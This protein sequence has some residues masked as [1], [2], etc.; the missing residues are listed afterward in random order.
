MNPDTAPIPPPLPPP[1]PA[2]VVV[3]S[4]FDLTLTYDGS[5]DGFGPQLQYDN[6]YI[7]VVVSRQQTG[8]NSWLWTLKALQPTLPD[9][10]T[11]FTFTATTENG[12]ITLTDAG[13][14][15]IVPSVYAVSGTL[16][17]DPVGTTYAVGDVVTVT[18]TYDGDVG[19]TIQ[20]NGSPFYALGATQQ[21]GPSKFQFSMSPAMP[22]MGVI[23]SVPSFACP[24]GVTTPLGSNNLS[25]VRAWASGVKSSVVISP[26]WQ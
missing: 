15:T 22:M 3:G 20:P 25:F 13:G 7:Q 11:P 16:T 18:V 14:F 12:L 9:T 17:L 1:N 10:P 6:A 2:T 4:T 8:P 24:G 19:N 21:I 23:V 26:R 5:V